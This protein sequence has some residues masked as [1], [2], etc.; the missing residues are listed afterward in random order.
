MEDRKDLSESTWVDLKLMSIEATNSH[1]LYANGLQQ[2]ELLVRV[3]GIDANGHDEAISDEELQSLELFDARGTDIE[4]TLQK[5][6]DSYSY[7]NDPEVE[8]KGW[9]WGY[10][11]NAEI[12]PLSATG[13]APPS[14][15]PATSTH[16]RR[17]KIYLH[18][19]TA[20]PL[21]LG[22]R[23]TQQ[24]GDVFHSGDMAGGVARLLSIPPKV[25][26]PAHYTFRHDH[27]RT[28][29]NAS[30]N[31]VD[32]ICYTLSLF[33]NGARIEFLPDFTVPGQVGMLDLGKDIQ[34][35]GTYAGTSLSGGHE[36]HTYIE[37]AHLPRVPAS[38]KR[39]G[40]I[41][42]VLGWQ[43]P[44][45]RIGDHFASLQPIFF[46]TVDHYG[47]AHNIGVSFTE[48]KQALKLT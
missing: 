36:F 21:H 18:T 25:Y 20:Q 19:R 14:P 43:T 29:L 10:R 13:D 31:E 11:R 16:E 4:I 30:G 7:K 12:L 22:F 46:K 41:P 26:S 38:V 9:G 45:K 34:Q 28:E 27:R 17:V 15:T 2:V 3:L 39:S 8:Y 1:L 33:E 42:L 44:L 37:R 35:V 48:D 40:D 23:I 5:V 6:Q 32:F 24:G 47:N